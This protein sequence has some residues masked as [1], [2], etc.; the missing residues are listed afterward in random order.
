[1]KSQLKKSDQ[2]ALDQIDAVFD[3]YTDGDLT[4]VCCEF[5]N[6]IVIGFV[7]LKGNVEYENFIN[8]SDENVEIDNYQLLDSYFTINLPINLIEVSGYDE[9]DKLYSTYKFYPY[10]QIADEVCEVLLKN[11][12]DVMFFPNESIVKT[13]FAYWHRYKASIS[14]DS[15]MDSEFEV[16]TIVK[17]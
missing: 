16:A 8:D 3:A 4:M 15:D 9:D 6:E 17:S 11:N 2:F 14:D 10:K 7:D 13:Y 1:M 12:P 5:N